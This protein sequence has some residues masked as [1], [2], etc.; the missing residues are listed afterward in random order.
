MRA[1]LRFLKTL[2]S[3]LGYDHNRVFERNVRILSLDIHKNPAQPGMRQ[4]V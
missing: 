1:T 2:D 3:L 4:M